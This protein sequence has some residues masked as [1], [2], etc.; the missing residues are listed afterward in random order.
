MASH[1]DWQRVANHAELR[2][3][4]S[5]S[6]ASARSMARAAALAAEENEKNGPEQELEEMLDDELERRYQKY[7]YC[8]IESLQHEL[9]EDTP[10]KFRGLNRA[11]N[12]L[13]DDFSLVNFV[14]LDITSEQSIEGIVQR[15]DMALQYGE[16]EE[17][18]V[19]RDLDGE[20]GGGG[21]GGDDDFE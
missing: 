12:T 8:D 21:G 19:P 13:L 14:P 3:P 16:D 11:I 15:I 20:E 5:A 2:A 4:Y 9:D 7:F 18:K 1:P 6:A 17:V 10:D